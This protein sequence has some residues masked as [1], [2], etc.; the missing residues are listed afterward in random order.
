MLVYVGEG[1]RP[2]PTVYPRSPTRL[3][4]EFREDS[5]SGLPV[6]GRRLPEGAHLAHVLR[7]SLCMSIM[8]PRETSCQDWIFRQAQA[9]KPLD[10]A[11]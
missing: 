9:S 2:S 5:L 1:L 6:Y 7:Q 8:R 3:R 10:P 11:E 4:S